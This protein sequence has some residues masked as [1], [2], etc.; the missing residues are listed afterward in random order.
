[1]IEALTLDERQ[2]RVEGGVAVDEFWEAQGWTW[3]ENRDDEWSSAL[4]VRPLGSVFDACIQVVGRPFQELIGSPCRCDQEHFA[5]LAHHTP[6]AVFLA[7]CSAH[8]A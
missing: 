1:M 6:D 8:P 7:E 4:Y 2:L 3:Y 5:V